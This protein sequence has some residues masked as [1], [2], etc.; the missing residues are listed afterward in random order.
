MLIISIGHLLQIPGKKL[1]GHLFKIIMRGESKN[2]GYLNILNL[3]GLD[4]IKISKINNSY[5]ITTSKFDAVTGKL[6]SP[7]I[8][9]IDLDLLKSRQLT[10][11]RIRKFKSFN[12][13]FKPFTLR[14]KKMKILFILIV[15]GFISCTGCANLMRAFV[16]D[17][18]RPNTKQLE[19]AK[20]YLKKM[21][22]Q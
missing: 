18:P 7:E 12:R 3:K 22:H 21:S 9:A 6:L 13:R 16:P 8:E 1:P 19:T 4:L 15:A 17:S 20:K 11:Q 10:L 5:A 14:R 2:G